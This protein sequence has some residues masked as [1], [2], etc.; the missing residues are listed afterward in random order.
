MRN[1]ANGSSMR[2]FYKIEDI[3]TDHQDEHGDWIVEDWNVTHPVLTVWIE[4]EDGDIIAL[5][6]ATEPNDWDGTE[7]DEYER[8]ERE[9]CG[10]IGVD[11]E[12]IEWDL[13]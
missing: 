4:D 5:A 3:P 2:G 7:P 1:A 8:L 11:H 12:S 6:D 10:Q 9:V 13:K